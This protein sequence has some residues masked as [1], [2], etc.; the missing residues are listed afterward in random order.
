MATA[1]GGV[2]AVVH[3]GITR[4]TAFGAVASVVWADRDLPADRAEP[5]AFLLTQ[6]AAMRSNVLSSATSQRGARMG[7]AY[8]ASSN[9]GDLLPF[10][11]GAWDTTPGT[12]Q[13]IPTGLVLQLLSTGGLFEGAEW[14]WRYE[15]DASNQTRGAHDLRY[16]LQAHHPWSTAKAV[17][18][19]YALCFSSVF[20]RVVA[21]RLRS[22]TTVFDIAYRSA[23]V[24]DP[25][26][27]YTT[28]SYSPPVGRLPSA[29]GYS[30]IVEL[31]DGSLRWFY[32]YVPDSAGA[33]ASY[34][35]D[36]LTSQD[37]GATWRLATS[38]IVSR[39]YGQTHQ[40]F[41]LR[42]AVSGDWLRLEL[43]LGSTATQGIASL[44]SADRGA[45][46]GAPV[47]EPDGLDDLSNGDSFNAQE[48]NAIVGLG[49]VDGAFFRVRALASG[50]WRYEF[51]SRDGAWA[52]GGFT[53]G[54][55]PAVGNSKA[56]FL[57][58]GGAYVYLLVHTDNGAGANR[59]GNYSFLI[60]VDR[61]QAGW[62]SSAP[63]VGEWLLWGDDILGHTGS[64]R[65]GPKGGTLAWLGDRLGLLAGGID[66]EAG[67]GSADW[68][69]GTLAYW[70][71]Y[72]RRPVH[73][74][75]SV[76]TDELGSMFT[77]YWSAQYGPP[78]YS[79][80]S[81][82][83]PWGASFAGT[84]LLTWA[85][86]A[87]QITTGTT[88]RLAFS[89]SQA[90]AAVTQF[91][92]D[93]GVL[94]WTTRATAGSGGSQPSAVSA[95]AMRAPRWGASLQAL[96]SAGLSVAVGVHLSDDGRV[97][98]YDVNAVSTLFLSQPGVL[99]GITTGAW[100]DFRV[101]LDQQGG[102]VRAD[103][104]WARAG[105]STWSST[106]ALTLASGVLASAFQQVEWGHVSALAA[107]S[108]THEW[109]EAWWSRVE[110]LGQYAPS[111]PADLRGWLA[112]SEPQQVA[113]AVAVR[114][115]GGGG[116][117]GDT[118][119]APV[120]YEFGG[121]QLATPSPESEWRSTT[122]AE[123][124]LLLD[125]QRAAGDSEVLRFRHS[126]LAV[127]GTNSRYLVLEYGD[128]AGLSAPSRLYVDGRRYVATLQ[129]QALASS[130]VRV[131]AA[132]AAQWQ[133]GEL[134]GHY[135]RAQVHPLSTNPSIVRIAT[136][137]GDTLHFAGLTQGLFSYGITSGVTLDIWADRHLLAFDDYPLGV[138][139]I[140][141]PT[142]SGTRRADNDFPRYLRITIP[143]DAVQGAPPEGYW[144]IGSVVAGMT[145][146][147]T[148]PLDWRGTDAQ[149]GNVQLTTAVSGARTAYVAGQPRRTITGTSEGDVQRWR[150]AFRAT[151]RHL[152][153]YGAQPL[154]LCTDDQQ[155]SRAMLYARFRDST[156]LANAGWRYDATLSRWEQVGDLSVSFEEEV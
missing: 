112:S 117:D 78:A 5:R 48:L 151:V 132:Q 53:V 133:D 2:A 46:W 59:F 93:G 143:A 136:N 146:P 114:W 66:R 4:G 65:Y 85:T 153:L 101:A 139:C 126:A 94:G 1:A 144:R 131:N 28:A 99:A 14:G 119:T 68:K 13:P 113:Q 156:E 110:P 3:T 104:A 67:T 16:Q 43:W 77:N 49:T 62:S 50:T 38:G 100:Y 36:M 39:V 111:L 72:S 56:V 23:S 90:A 12:P 34:D 141:D 57:A 69:P 115:G 138:R 27:G 54:L 33:P 15:A 147:I 19:H 123:Q 86:D 82:F 105:D 152:G 83:T 89:V 80:A 154:V 47:A 44:Y 96:S 84:P 130:S 149:A 140:A 24:A 107:A 97:G 122:G 129:S 63:R 42:A 6:D 116:F 22:G 20:N 25:A 109:R 11:G 81:A 106:G 51:A 40:V 26:T 120:Q 155:Q 41:S 55:I 102:T 125:A 17:A 137:H 29:S 128:D 8:P 7:T 70:S 121:D 145:L 103:L 108:F 135:C 30:A 79:G 32:S 134:A 118:F 91:M 148:V 98:I 95:P 142:G 52:Q 150:E 21:V 60:P 37:G 71:G 10:L 45:T 64:M 58:R 18:G 74:A 9:E 31:P 35:V 88:S 124:Q 87:I 127:V 76:L 92:G 75:A 73:R 61:L